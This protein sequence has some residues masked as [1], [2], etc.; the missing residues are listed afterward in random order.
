MKAKVILVAFYNKKALGV[1]YL[2][3]ALL[4]S[5][6]DVRVVYFKDFNSLHPHHTTTAELK[7]LKGE[8]TKYRPHMIG[9]RSWLYRENTR[10]C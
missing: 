8:I 9:L 3:R 1:R 2:E 4:R 5:G 10:G 7:L 6:H